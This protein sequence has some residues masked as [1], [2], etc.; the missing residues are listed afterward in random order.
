MC[1]PSIPRVNG[2]FSHRLLLCHPLQ[3]GY[4]SLESC[5]AET[6]Y[7]TGTSELQGEGGG[8]CVTGLKLSGQLH[9]VAS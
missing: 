6:V 2:R 5:D 8:T 1:H 9:M 4:G 7:P 3:V